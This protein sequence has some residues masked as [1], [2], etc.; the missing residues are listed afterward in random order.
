[1]NRLLVS[2]P[3]SRRVVALANQPYGLFFSS[4]SS[5]QQ[6]QQQQQQQQ[7]QPQPCWSSS[8]S[9]L[10]SS[11]LSSFCRRYNP[12]LTTTSSTLRFQSTATAAYDQSIESFPSIVIG[13]DRSIEPQGSFAESQAQVRHIYSYTFAFAFT[14]T[15]TPILTFPMSNSKRTHTQKHTHTHSS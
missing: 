2:S 14:F 7:K 11:S 15:F 12:S 1:M 4:L 5:Q 10:S 6:P 9:T 13:A 8:F 3:L